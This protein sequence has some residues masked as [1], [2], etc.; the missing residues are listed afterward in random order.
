LDL[1]FAGT[2]EDEKEKKTKGKRN[3]LIPP[4]EGYSL[5]QRLLFLFL[6][7]GPLRHPP[8]T[9]LE[10]EGEV[11]YEVCQSSCISVRSI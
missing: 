9:F 11:D 7:E 6:K 10:G 8:L 1:A 2:R 4:F 3:G 5:G